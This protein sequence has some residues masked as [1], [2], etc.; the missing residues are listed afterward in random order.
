MASV[1]FLVGEREREKI[2]SSSSGGLIGFGFLDVTR[3]CGHD[4]I[5]GT[6]GGQ[7]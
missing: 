2:A 3:F 5:G 6:R 1:I 4:E 7:Q